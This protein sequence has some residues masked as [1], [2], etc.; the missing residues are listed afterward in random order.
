MMT[1][2]ISRIALLASLLITLPGCQ[3][4]LAVNEHAT[5][6]TVPS[7]VGFS[8]AIQHWKSA[9]ESDYARHTPDQ[10]QKIADNILLLQ[11]DHG[12]WVQNQDPQRIVI[13]ADRSKL[14]KDKS[15][16]SGS[17][18][19]RNVYTQI[20][21]LM[22]AY[23][24]LGE[25]DHLEGA[26]KGLNYLLA[27]Q[28]ETCGG[29]PHSVPGKAKYHPMLTVAD[30]VLSGPLTLLRQISTGLPPFQKIGSEEQSRATTALQNAE[31][32]LLSLQVEQGTARTGWAGQYNPQTLEP[33]FG[34]SFEL[35]SITTEETA[36]I[37]NYL[38]S[39]EDPN[40]DVRR[41]VESGVS[42]LEGVAIPD[43]RL[44]IYELDEPVRFKFH[45]A[46]HDRR[47]VHDISAP[48][49]WARFYDLEDNSVVLANR[50][51]IRVYD[52]QNVT[53][54]RRTG[55]HWFGTWGNEILDTTY[56][57]WKARLA[58]NAKP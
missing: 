9:N 1:S 37:L 45:T 20:A 27:H 46:T 58:L 55:Y 26:R 8:D 33:V 39:I 31:A 6:K 40:D 11:R 52:Y 12:G 7:L 57:S 49:L 29:W 24:L 22:G 21:Y 16:P 19:N 2:S 38:M 14:L 43:T 56:P 15:K 44:E 23:E 48:R 47:L 13:G 10:T 50:D 5:E 42:W 32:C 25:Q 41:A 30:E 17:F 34:R 36:Y 35:P 54:E 4:N 18:D 28:M 3:T 51:S 53:Q